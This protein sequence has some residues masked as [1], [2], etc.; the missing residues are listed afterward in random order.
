MRA[1]LAV[2]QLAWSPRAAAAARVGA[3]ADLETTSCWLACSTH[4]SLNGM[5][6]TAEL[7][8]CAPAAKKGR[9]FKELVWGVWDSR[10]CARRD[11]RTSRAQACRNRG[12]WLSARG[13]RFAPGPAHAGSAMSPRASRRAEDTYLVPLRHTTVRGVSSACPLIK[14]FSAPSPSTT[15][16]HVRRLLLL[17][18]SR[19]SRLPVLAT[20]RLG[21]GRAR[22][23]LAKRAAGP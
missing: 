16:I 13:R 10:M 21:L 12:E 19:A 1:Q 8:R 20:A 22:V 23:G 2:G 3:D 15:P 4:H 5:N 11:A 6:P 18:G 7:R 14:N 17:A 9:I